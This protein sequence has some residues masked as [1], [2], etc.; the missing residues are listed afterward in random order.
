MNGSVDCN[1]M[2]ILTK[3]YRGTVSSVQ[4][5]EVEFRFQWYFLSWP[6]YYYKTR[7]LETTTS[8]SLDLFRRIPHRRD[9]ITSPTLWNCLIESSIQKLNQVS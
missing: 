9:L 3:A 2:K 6:L 7:N 5:D 8:G 4:S 1:E